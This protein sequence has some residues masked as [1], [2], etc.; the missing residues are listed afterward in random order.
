MKKSK[1]ESGK[2]GSLGRQKFLKNQR[3][4]YDK[5]PNRC[6]RCK[7]ILSFKKR[8]STFCSQECVKHKET[9]EMK[10]DG[11]RRVFMIRKYGIR[12]WICKLETWNDQQIPIELDHID[13]N[14]DNNFE[15]NLRLLCPNCHAQQPTHAGKNTKKFPGT[16]RQSKYRRMYIAAGTGP[17]TGQGSYP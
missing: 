6:S 5:N 2:L 12:C 15:S 13:G 11:T 3:E 17:V 8:N 16:K 4:E 1:S 10:K 9:H 7:G 14:S